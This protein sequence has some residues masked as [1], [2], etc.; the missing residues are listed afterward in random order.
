MMV[1][2]D[3]GRCGVFEVNKSIARTQICRPRCT[4]QS[5]VDEECKVLKAHM[6]NRNSSVGTK[7]ALT[8]ILSYGRGFGGLHVRS[9]DCHHLGLN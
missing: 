2:D 3:E 9:I 1:I 5:M 8:I 6:S 4:V 7:P